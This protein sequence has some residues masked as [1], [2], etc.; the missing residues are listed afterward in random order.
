MNRHRH[1]QQ[2]CKRRA[3]AHE[4]EGEVMPGA[5]VA[6]QPPPRT[7][8]AVDCVLD[9]PSGVALAYCA[10]ACCRTRKAVRPQRETPACHHDLACHRAQRL[11]GAQL[12]V[13]APHRAR[14]GPRLVPLA[15]TNSSSRPPAPPGRRPVPNPRDRAH[16]ARLLDAID[17]VSQSHRPDSTPGQLLGVPGLQLVLCRSSTLAKARGRRPL[18]T[19]CDGLGLQSLRDRTWAE[20][21]VVLLAGAWWLA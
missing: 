17:E 14:P 9:R 5:H 12:R 16:T 3:G 15:I 10:P 21:S 6:P 20:A 4:S 13:W 1:K 19:S 7:G 8:T 11:G 18:R 2:P